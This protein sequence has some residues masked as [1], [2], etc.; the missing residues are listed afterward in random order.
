M[1]KIAKITPDLF[2]ITISV[3]PFTIQLSQFLVRD[4][5][6][7]GDA[8]ASPSDTTQGCAHVG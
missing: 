3:E 4:D 5:R 2:L 6:S 7:C 8:V 1:A